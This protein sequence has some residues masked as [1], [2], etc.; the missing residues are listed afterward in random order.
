MNIK[1]IAC[2]VLT[3][4]LGLA[5][6]QSDNF[7]DI[8]SMRQGYHDTPSILNKYLQDEI[9]SVESGDNRYT[10]SVIDKKFD[11]I[12]LGYGL[13]SGGVTGLKSSKYPLIIPRAHDCITLFL[14]SKERYT[15]EFSENPGT[16]WYTRG[17]VDNVLLPSGQYTQRQRDYYADKFGYDEEEVDFLIEQ[18]MLWIN[19][20]TQ[21]GYIHMSGLEN[22]ASEQFAK[23]AAVDL[24]WNYKRFDGDMR[25]IYDMVNGTWSAEDFLIL[26]PGQS[27]AE[28][29][30]SDVIG[31][32]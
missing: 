14:G 29:Y 9:D 31:K 26:E 8:T 23:D 7:I 2:K 30:G 18:D 1:I 32:A 24:S 13:C 21:A 10:C 12:V 22:G 28:T 17:W 19:N 15:R 20:Y 11:A 6:A 27:V 4:E 3:R 5:A 16:Y 25:L